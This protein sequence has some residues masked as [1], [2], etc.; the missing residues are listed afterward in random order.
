MHLCIHN[1]RV[2]VKS[3]RHGPQPLIS[4]GLRGG[5]F[6]LRRFEQLG[7]EESFAAGAIEEDLVAIGVPDGGKRRRPWAVQAKIR[8]TGPATP[9][10]DPLGYRKRS[11]L[12]L[13]LSTDGG[14]DV[15][16]K[17][18]NALS[19]LKTGHHYGLISP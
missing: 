4:Q 18:L 13:V 15:F 14:V 5:Q 9:Q 6:A 17:I 11:L 19:L 16:P 8:A 1:C 3:F 2:A 7:F 10:Q 12:E